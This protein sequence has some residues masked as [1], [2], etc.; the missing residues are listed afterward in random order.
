LATQ[1]M[2]SGDDAISQN[3]MV[4][5]AGLRDDRQV[6]FDERLAKVELVCLVE[7]LDQIGATTAPELPYLCPSAMARSSAPAS[8][9]RAAAACPWLSSIAA[10]KHAA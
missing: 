5:Q 10:E 1:K 3:Q 7:Q 6:G 2:Q 8:V 9:A 4:G